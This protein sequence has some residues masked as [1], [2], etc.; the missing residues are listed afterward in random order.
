LNREGERRRPVV[1]VVTSYLDRSD[2]GYEYFLRRKF[3]EACQRRNFD[4]LV[5]CVEA[6][7]DPRAE[8]VSHNQLFELIDG[9]KIDGIV[10]LS[11]G[12]SAYIGEL[13]LKTKLERLRHIPQC[14]LGMRIE[15]IPSV[16]SDCRAGMTELCEHVLIHHRRRRP[17]FVG[18]LWDNAEI[19]ERQETFLAVCAK[20]GISVEPHRLIAAGLE[21]VTAQAATAKLLEEDPEVDAIFAAN[22]SSAI[23]V[24]RALEVKKIRVPEQ[25]VVTGYDDVPSAQVLWRPLTTV[26]QPLFELAELAIDVIAAQLSGRPVPQCQQ[27][28]TQVV[29]RE[30]CGCS[31]DTGFS[32]ANGNVSRIKVSYPTLTGAKSK[33]E[34]RENFERWLSSIPPTVDLNDA[35]KVLCLDN[36]TPEKYAGLAGDETSR[37]LTLRADAHERLLQHLEL[38]N[39]NVQILEMANRFS[40]AQD[41][42]ELE[43]N[44]ATYLPMIHTQ[45]LVMGLFIDESHRHLRRVLRIKNGTI[46]D[47]TGEL[48][49]VHSNLLTELFDSESPRVCVLLALTIQDEFLGVIG[50]HALDT[51]FDYLLMR[52]HIASALQVVRLH[53]EVVKRTMESE[54]NAKE[55]QA[56]SDRMGALSALAAGVAHDLNN[57]LGSLVALTD[58]VADEVNAG[59]VQGH[60]INPDIVN[61]L[62]AMKSG[63]LRAVETIK[64]LMTLGRIGRPHQEPFDV[65]RLTRRTV[66]ELKLVAQSRF[67]RNFEL[68]CAVP[69]HEV[70]VVGSETHVERAIGNLL[71]NA[72]DASAEGGK[73]DVSIVEADL[74]QTWFGYES[75][76]AGNYAVITVKDQGFGIEKEQLRQVFEP[77]FSTKRLREDSG[78]GLGLAIVHS[79]TKEHRG[80]VDVVSSPGQGAQFTLYL[81]Q[82]KNIAVPR[83]RSIPVTHGSARILV[84]DDDLTQLRTA[85]RVLTRLGYDVVTT[86]SGK[87]AY[88]MV[89]SESVAS[90]ERQGDASGLHVSNRYDLIIMDLS[91]REEDD[92]LTVVRRIRRVLPTQ[93]G[94][95]ASGHAFPDHEE[96][97]RDAG[98]IWLPKPYTVE[99]LINAIH[100]ALRSG[101]ST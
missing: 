19:E 3:T 10:T 75:I 50:F 93:K 33:G 95:L 78:S 62:D 70:V 45:D 27:L 46:S 71:R 94:I 21:A 69:P 90:V 43:M 81:P 101:T 91:L 100:E 84:V 82:V 67:G 64:D 51:Y 41:V 35:V 85:K 61:D 24:L 1:A 12:L 37:A 22:D 49:Q 13:G 17:S 87:Q 89:T 88:D 18:S 53:D 99:L 42:A 48:L 56:A 79:V 8:K 7:E 86:T 96:E 16:I 44:L 25:V 38:E 15:G 34:L 40:R 77:F 32:T 60:P 98:L 66:E 30:S 63:A 20:L 52:D 68:S 28:P 72:C 2:G 73:I 92:G 54:R 5:M 26:R 97:I 55:K 14:S 76:P 31:V 29:I 23:G 74:S 47:A 36:L 65:A 58:I 6:F 59:L 4:L 9:S 11:S 83:E 57:A 80:Y 39:A